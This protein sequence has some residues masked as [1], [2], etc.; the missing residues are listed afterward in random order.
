MPRVVEHGFHAQRLKSLTGIDAGENQARR[1]L[2]D[3]RRYGATLESAPGKRCAESVAAAAGWTSGSSRPSRR[4]RATCV[5]KL[6]PAELYHQVLEH[7][8]FISE[9]AGYDVGMADTIDSYVRNVL[10]PARHE[11]ITLPP[12]TLELQAITDDMARPDDRD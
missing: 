7:R 6:E 3:I 12:L 5:G 9:A 4:S 10:A 11:Q 8:W 2:N 1:L